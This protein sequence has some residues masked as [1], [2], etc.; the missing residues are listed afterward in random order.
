V[1]HEGISGEHFIARGSYSKLRRQKLVRAPDILALV[2][3]TARESKRNRTI[4]KREQKHPYTNAIFK[5]FSVIL[6]ARV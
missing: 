5:H 4:A 1:K 6:C 3:G 2:N